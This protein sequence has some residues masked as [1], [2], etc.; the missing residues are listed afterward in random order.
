MKFWKFLDHDANEVIAAYQA[1][2]AASEEDAR[3]VPEAYYSIA[4]EYFMMLKDFDKAKEYQKKAE[5]AEN[6]PVRLPC[7]EPIKD[8]FPPKYSLKLLHMVE[9]EKL[10][11]KVA[12]CDHCGKFGA[13]SCCSRCKKVKYCDRECQKKHWKEH[14]KQCT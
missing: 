8:D 5:R 4:C 14:K 12:K 9:K 7:F 11:N 13:S 1:Y 3:K 6:S 10:A 2:I